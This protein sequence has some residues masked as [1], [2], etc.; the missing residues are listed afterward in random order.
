MK[1]NASLFIVLAFGLT[2]CVSGDSSKLS[3]SHPA[4]P[5]APSSPV[6]AAS[7]M[8]L[9]NAQSLVL[10]ASTNQA[11]LQHELH[12]AAPPNQPAQKPAEHKHHHEQSNPEEKK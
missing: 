12:Q 2:G 6:A 1:P 3:A 9:T 10:P 7:P 4:N 11:D 5:H 8:L